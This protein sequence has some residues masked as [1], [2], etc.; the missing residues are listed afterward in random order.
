[1]RHVQLLSIDLM[2]IS[3]AD[4]KIVITPPTENEDK[5]VVN[6]VINTTRLA[7]A[8][9]Y[10]EIVDND[11]MPMLETASLPKDMSAELQRRRY[12]N[13][14]P[15]IEMKTYYKDIVG[16][17]IRVQD[18]IESG[19]EDESI[20]IAKEAFKDDK[21]RI[22][23]MIRMATQYMTPEERGSYMKYIAGR[24]KNNQKRD[25]GTENR[26]YLSL[27][28]EEFLKWLI[29]MKLNEIDFAGYKLLGNKE[30]VEGD[31]VW[32]ENG[33]AG[34][35]I[36]DGTYTGWLTV[37]EFNHTL[38]GAVDIDDL[39]VVPE[40]NNKIIVKVQQRFVKDKGADKIIRS[41]NTCT[42]VTF[43][44]GKNCYVM[45]VIRPDGASTSVPYDFGPAFFN[46]F[47]DMTG[48][49][50]KVSKNTVSTEKGDIIDSVYV[51]IDLDSIPESV[52]PVDV[53]EIT[54]E[55]PISF[56]IEESDEL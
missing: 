1:M 19:D 56:D 44:A 5:I 30:Y 13:V 28:R 26:F 37:K 3:F 41:L 54:E 12:G 48:K 24:T 2:N 40:V 8:D 23:N 39:I 49:I 45:D 53:P 14:T 16:G 35:A 25:G 52:A 6:D 27:C 34:K 31:I 7:F 36:I 4:G 32:F 22:E 17:Y 20:T 15:F 43:K 50:V 9:E 29:S 18:D 38:Y 51:S 33:Q 10:K 46:M 11:I 47:K 42:D 21:A 55:D